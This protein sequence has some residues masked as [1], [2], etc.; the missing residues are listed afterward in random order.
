M[1]EFMVEFVTNSNFQRPHPNSLLKNR[2]LDASSERKPI[3]SGR[4]ASILRFFNRLLLPDSSGW[5]GDQPAM[6]GSMIPLAA[7][8][9]RSFSR[10]N[11][12]RL[13]VVGKFDSMASAIS[14][15]LKP[16]N[17]YRMKVNR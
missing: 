5:R 16:A 10:A 11:L 8:F 2:S 13:L 4:G 15:K 7:S 6:F 17:E 14:G 3:G 9:S 12:R 1:I